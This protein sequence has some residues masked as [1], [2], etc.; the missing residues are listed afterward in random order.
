[1]STHHRPTRGTALALAA[2]LAL[3]AAAAHA[4]QQIP[5]ALPSPRLLLVTPPGARAGTSVEV[6]LTGT[7]L[8]SP[9]RL[10]FSHPGI[11]AEPVVAPAPPKPAPGK[12]PPPRPRRG[13]AMGTPT[14]SKFKVTVPADVPVGIQDVR[15]VNK[16]GVSNPRAFVVGDLAE[17]AEKEPNN[18]QPESQRVEINSTVN[19]AM[20]SPVDVDYF[21]FAGKKGQR[22]VLSCLASSIDSRFEPN[23]ELYDGKNNLLASNHAYHGNDALTDCTL[24]ADGD[25]YVRLAEFTYTRGTAEHFYRLSITTAPWID[26]VH[27]CVVEPGKSTPV[28]VYGRNLP[29]GKLNPLAVDGDRTLE[30]VD[31]TVTAPSDLNRLAFSGYVPPGSAALA[32]FEFRVRNAAGASNPFLLALAR[33]PVVRDNDANDTPETAQALTVPCEVAGRIEKRRDRD[34]YTFAAKKGDVLAIDVQSERLGAPTF[35]YFMLRDEKGRELFESQD[36]NMNEFSRKFWSRSD[37]PAPYRFAV[38]ADGKYQLLVGSRTGD[39]LAGPRHYYRLR[40]AP[41]RPDFELVAMAGDSTRPSGAAVLAGGN[42]SLTVVALR[43]G[44]FSSDVALSVEGLPP[45]VTCPPQSLGGGQREARIALHADA[46]AKPWAG[47]IKVK[48]TATVRGQKVVR[49]ARPAGI[50]WPVQPQQN[51]PTISRLDRSLLLAVGGPAPWDLGLTLDKP[52]LTQG[53]RGTIKL[54]LK[55]LW[56]DFKGALAVQAQNEELPRGLNVNNNQ[57]VNVAAGKNDGSL[58]VVVTNQVPP[59]LYTVVLRAQAQVPYNR[60]P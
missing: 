8:E 20:A 2:L 43:E 44:G 40:I 6:T 19:G 57:P 16:W 55:R 37:D 9:D 56:P 54:N 51:T 28:T 60:D 47:E 33:S 58:N 27:P 7:D 5:S 59:G 45:G 1:M 12:A 15:L 21:V 25:Y 31:V 23:L 24:P 49:E 26:A 46:T 10:V 42:G 18:D 13:M 35:M 41:E 34:W 22:V 39:T 14:V 52:A 11:K 48:G 50:V 30:S 4:Q 36:V 17:V 32:G 53:E 38:P 29:G 3:G